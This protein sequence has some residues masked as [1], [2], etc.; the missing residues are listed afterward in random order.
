MTETTVKQL[1]SYPI[2]GLTPSECDRVFLTEGHGIK[3]D[4]AFALMFADSMDTGTMPELADIPWLSKK[5]FAVQND[6]PLLAA[7]KCQYEPETAVLQ[8]NR[9]GIAVLNAET[10]TVT[11]R[12][13]IGDFFTKYINTIEPTKEARHPTRSPLLLV[14]D[15]SGE[16][17]YPDRE[18]VHISILSQA[19]LNN[20][21]EVAGTLVDVRRF[22]PNIVID[23]VAAW[24]EFNL[25]GKEFQLGKARILVTAKIG[26]CV[27]IEVDPY[28]GDRNLPLLSL[29]QEQFGHAQTGVLAKIVSS[30]NVAIGDLLTVNS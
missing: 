15:S 22:R 14:G 26:R 23:G 21:S 6:W 11:G 9:E 3:G 25:V 27:N 5:H 13:L 1:F 7:L 19:T 20:L 4:R 10:K 28:T 8:V 24:E 16:T 18:P 2:K 12:K 29:L 30:G 17:R